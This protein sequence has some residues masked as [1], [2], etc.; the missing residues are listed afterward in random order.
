M[1]HHFKK[2]LF[3]LTQGTTQVVDFNNIRRTAFTLAEVLITLGIIGVVA[4][5]TMPSLIANYKNKVLVNQAKSSYS[6]LSNALIMAKSQNGFESYSELF[7]PAYTNDQI[8]EILSKDLKMVKI[9]KQN[10][11]GCFNWKTKYQKKQYKDGKT[12][13]YNNG[14]RSSAVL[15]DGSV[16]AISKFDHNGDCK[17]TNTYNKTDDKGN[18]VK[19]ENGNIIVINTPSTRCGQIIVDV[20]GAKGPNQQGAD[21]WDIAVY[22]QYLG[23]TGSKGALTFLHSDKLEYENYQEG[24][25]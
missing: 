6:K 9:C 7:G 10:Q 3:A 12:I 2:H 13:Y 4:A 24:V 22:Q 20:N 1:I 23:G 19:D 15:S 21:T 25:E 16:I 8:V 11:G 17:W 14:Y 18:P 5:M